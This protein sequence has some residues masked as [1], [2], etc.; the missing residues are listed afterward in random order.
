MRRVFQFGSFS[1]DL[2]LDR[3]KKAYLSLQLVMERCT[4]TFHGRQLQ[5]LPASITRDVIATVFNVSNYVIEMMI[6]IV[7]WSSEIDVLRE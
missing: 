1:V 3:I 2:L 7:I 5:M 4:L 6:V